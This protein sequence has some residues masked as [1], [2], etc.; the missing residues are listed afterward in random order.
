MRPKGVCWNCGEKGHYKNKC[1]KPTLEKPKSGGSTNTVVDWDSDSE[2]VF[3]VDEMSDTSLDGMP[4]LESVSDFS[5]EGSEVGD[6]DGSGEDWFSDVGEDSDSPWYGRIGDEES[7]G[8]ESELSLFFAVDSDSESVNSWDFLS[9]H[10]KYPAET[11]ANVSD[12]SETITPPRK[13][14]FD[15]GST[16]HISPY[17]KDFKNFAEIPPKI[18][19]AANKQ[20][21]SAVGKGDLVIEVPNGVNTSKL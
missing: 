3:G 1:P 15:S 12:H 18:F 4:T 14:L 6:E 11:V 10:P 2:G 9:D 16:R 21:F 7:S 20:A 19:V 8:D 13:E 17:L 5:E